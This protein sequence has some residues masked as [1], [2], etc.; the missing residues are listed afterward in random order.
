M[1]VA[2]IQD[3]QHKIDC[4]QGRSDKHGLTREGVL[5]RLRYPLK[6]AA[7]GGWQ[8]N[9]ARRPLNRRDR[10]AQCR[11]GCEIERDGDGR[12][13]AL[14]IDDER[15]RR[16]CVVG[17]G[18]ERHQIAV[19][20]PHIDV[21]EAIGILQEARLHFQHHMVLIQRLVHRGD[22]TLAEGIIERIVDRRGADAEA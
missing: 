14:V 16:R 20:R 19:R 18:T 5:K 10:V 6:A 11:V 17:E 3:T 13:Q 4:H 1:N 15:R 2:F 22:L 12:K 9:L 8:A 21:L 7:Y